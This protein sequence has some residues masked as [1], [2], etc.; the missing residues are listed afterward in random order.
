MATIRLLAREGAGLAVVP[1]IVVENELSTGL[2]KEA[3]QVPRLVETFYAIT[4][5]RRRGAFPIR[6]S[7]NSLKAG[8]Y[9]DCDH[10]GSL[11]PR[12]NRAFGTVPGQVRTLRLLGKI[13]AS[14]ALVPM[15]NPD[16]RSS[17]RCGR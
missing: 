15:S 13:R 6:C 2:L 14:W 10:C 12:L 5:L 3:M 9:P 4:P 1:P 16:F 17:G 7:E 8:A 11:V